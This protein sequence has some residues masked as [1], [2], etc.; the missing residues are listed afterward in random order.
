[1]HGRCPAGIYPWLQAHGLWDGKGVVPT[2][3]VAA[4][5]GRAIG[6]LTRPEVLLLCSWGGAPGVCAWLHQAMHVLLLVG[7]PSAACRHP[8]R[9]YLHVVELI[10]QR[11]ELEGDAHGVG[12]TQVPEPRWQASAALVHMSHLGCKHTREGRWVASNRQT[13]PPPMCF[14]R[15]RHSGAS[16]GCVVPCVHA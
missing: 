13:L 4:G 1:M 2:V 15:L 10:Q 8:A 5:G 11:K 14:Y 3:A 9:I 7:S 6:R 16:L 12:E